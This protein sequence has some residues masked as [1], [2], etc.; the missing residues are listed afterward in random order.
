MNCVDYSS[1]LLP[2]LTRLLNEQLSAM[3]PGWLLKED[4]VA[5]IIRSAPEMWRTHFPEQNAVFELETHCVLDQGRLVAAAELGFPIQEK[6]YGIDNSGILFWIVAE[7]GHPESARLL[8]E[9]I[10][11]R[12][13][14]AGSP[15]IITTRF[16][17]GV[18][19]LGI[20]AY[21][22]HVIEALQSAGYEV[23]SCWVILTASAKDTPEVRKPDSIVSMQTSWHIDEEALEWDL[24]L[25][26]NGDLVG[27]CSAWGIPP[28]FSG[29][30]GFES[31]ITIE[32]L[33]V[34]Q[35][36]WRKSI[37]RWLVTEQLRRQ[38]QRGISHA[39]LWTETDNQ[40]FLSLAESLGFEAGP[41]CWEFEKEFANV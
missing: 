40:P 34:E 38:A 8:L 21:W 19:W 37:G 26:A 27:E 2:S 28:Y 24:R 12:A 30:E 33:G 1:D 23:S 25:H 6:T 5:Q 13:R 32:W 31:W 9:I 29:C 14:A 7:S 22:S 4:Q 17:F 11:A 36:Y 18:G 39:I 15:R 3:P 10:E 35:A 16:S 20:P 41:E